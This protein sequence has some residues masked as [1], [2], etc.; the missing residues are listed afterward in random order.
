MR[1]E[2]KEICLDKLKPNSIFI[3]LF[4]FFYRVSSSLSD[5][6]THITAFLTLR[7]DP[8]SL[9]DEIMIH[10]KS[11]NKLGI[12]RGYLL[13]P[14][15]LKNRIIL[16]CT[17]NYNYVRVYKCNIKISKGGSSF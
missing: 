16:L 8:I 3:G 4:P 13:L 6:K 7:G 5:D 12:S 9:S 17:L 2:I 15:V 10:L 14:N 1:Q 11:A